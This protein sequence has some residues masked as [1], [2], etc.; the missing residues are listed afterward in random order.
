MQKA[1]SLIGAALLLAGSVCAGE[2]GKPM[3]SGVYLGVNGGWLGSADDSITNTATDT[4]PAGLGNVFN[5]GLIPK[6]V[7]SSLSGFI[8]G[9]QIG[10]N[11]QIGSIV[12]GVEAD[13][14]AIRAEKDSTTAIFP[15]SLGTVPFS[16]AFAR[17]ADWLA[18]VRGRLGVTVTPSL[19]GYG[20][21]GFAAG[22]ALVSNGFLCPTCAPP[23]NTTS[24]DSALLTGWT[25]GGGAE[26]MFASNWS[27][28]AEYL[29]VDLGD[30][31]T[32]TVYNYGSRTSSLTSKL[33]ETENIVRAGLNYHF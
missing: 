2:P 24:P 7:G 17:D 23:A 6:S 21:G 13:L 11:W 26:W 14:D 18:T 29:Y 30:H 8:G 9:A 10:Y 20:T 22:R 1:L 25:A 31:S 5:R 28:K 16:T 19:L 12:F 32:T 15:G 33:S 3:W 4:G 27:L